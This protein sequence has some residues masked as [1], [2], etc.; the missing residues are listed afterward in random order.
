MKKK[1][2]SKTVSFRLSLEEKQLVKQLAEEKGLSEAKFLEDIVK[3]HIQKNLA[4]NDTFNLGDLAISLDMDEPELSFDQMATSL[5]PTGLKLRIQLI[6]YKNWRKNLRAECSKSIWE[7]LRAEQLSKSN[8][9]CSICG[10][11]TTELHCHEVW[12]ID[13]EKL[14]QVLVGLQIVCEYCHHCIHWGR[15]RKIDKDGTL[16]EKTTKHFLKVN[17]CDKPTFIKHQNEQMALF[18]KNS[19]KEYKLDFGDYSLY[20]MVKSL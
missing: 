4:K 10:D 16:T 3:P 6:P 20:A 8:N 11:N 14:T 13:H 2:T 12:D 1:T 17:K 7:A 5:E 9:K 18:N 19:E 15:M